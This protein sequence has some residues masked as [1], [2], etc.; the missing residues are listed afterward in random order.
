MPIRVVCPT[1]SARLTAPDAAAGRALNVDGSQSLTG[2]QLRVNSAGNLVASPVDGKLYLV[3][4]DNRNGVHNS[5][6]PITNINVFLMVSSNGGASWGSP[7]LVDS[8]GGDQWFPWVDVN[9]TNGAIG[10]AGFTANPS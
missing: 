5:P 10:S 8:G 7:I 3:F 4:S 1:C 9:P 6:N 2:Y